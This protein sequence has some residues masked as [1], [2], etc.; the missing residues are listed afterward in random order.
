M[1]KEKTITL[2]NKNVIVKELNVETIFKFWTNLQESIY[3]KT[4]SEAFLKDMTPFF[5]KC[6]EGI[7]YEELTQN[8][9]SELK[10]LYETFREV[11]ADFFHLAEV[12]EGDNPLLAGFRMAILADLTTKFANSYR[13][14]IQ[15]SLSM[16]MDSSLQPSPLGNESNERSISG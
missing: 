9:P 6:V 4:G 11:N 7:T 2:G 10:I 3:V 16:D 8:Y 14:D 15:E 5:D 12:V 1:R 13:P